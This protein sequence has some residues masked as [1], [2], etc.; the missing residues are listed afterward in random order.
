MKYSREL[1]VGLSI[2]AAAI[3]FFVG[4]RYFQDLPVFRGSYTMFT[5]F[6]DAQGLVNGSPVRINGVNVGTVRNVELR[7]SLDDVQVEFQLHQ[8][9]EVPQGSVATVA[10]M[11][12]LGNVQLEIILGP[13]SAPAYPEES[14]IPSQRGDAIGQILDRAPA[15]AARADTV[16]TATQATIQDLQLIVADQSVMLAQT[17]R[18]MNAAAQ[19]FERLLAANDDRVGRVLENAEAVSTDLRTISASSGDS[20]TL[21]LQRFNQV[22]TRLDAGLT[23]LQRTAA[24]IDSLVAGVQRGNGT[25]GRLANDPSIYLQ[26]DSTLTNLNQLLIGFEQDPRRYLRELTLIDLF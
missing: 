22:M 13:G 14:T 21:A 26:L 25:I 4:V 5:S 20:L 24:G 11:E 8:G 23:D 2:V 19:R 9:V 18:S 6:D 17:M 1:I 7:T 15:L 16:L 3:I 12:M 10:G